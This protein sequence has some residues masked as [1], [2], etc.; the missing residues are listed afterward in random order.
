VNKNGILSLT[1]MDNMEIL[2]FVNNLNIM[3]EN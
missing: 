1:K 3:A 2:K